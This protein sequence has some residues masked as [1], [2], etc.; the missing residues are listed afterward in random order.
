[1]YTEFETHRERGS[2]WK[3][4]GICLILLSIGSFFAGAVILTGFPKSETCEEIQPSS[5]IAN[6]RFIIALDEKAKL[7]TFDLEK[8]AWKELEPIPAGNTSNTR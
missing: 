2:F 6:E 3:V 7:C 5:F 4:L 1:M 8:R